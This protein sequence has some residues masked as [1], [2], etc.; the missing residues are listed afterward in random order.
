[1]VSIGLLWTVPLYAEVGV[2]DTEIKIGQWGPQTGPA[3]LWGAVARGTDCYFKMINEE[4][5]INGRKLKLFIRDDAYQPPKT[6]EAV[7][8][9]VEK[10]GVFAFVGGVGTAPGMAVMDYLI[11]HKIPWLGMATGSEHWAHPPKKYVFATYPNYEDEAALLVKYAVENLK[12]KKIAFFYQNDEYGKGGL[13][14]AQ[15]MLG[16]MNL[17]LVTEIPVEVQDT[18]LVSHAM[19]LKASGAEAVVLWVLPKHAAIILGTSAKLGFTPQWMASSTLSDVPLMYDITKGLYKGIIYTSFAELPDSKLPLMEKYRQA[20]KKFA[21]HERWGVFFYAGIGLVEPMIEAIKRC[22]RDLTREKVVAQLEAMK[23]FQGVMGKVSF[24]P[25]KHQGQ[26][27]I[28]LAQ[29]EDMTIEKD[30]KPMKI[31]IGKKISDWIEMP[32]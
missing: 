5:G 6:K 30:G 12:K 23:N 31:G 29:C 4:G 11:E 27:A 3:A 14:G 7:K 25:K 20:W 22:G 17:K 8:E 1:M 16:K 9:L 13:R 15:E 32:D 26:R 21:P 10:E 18:D 28:F 2:T 24:G 19:K